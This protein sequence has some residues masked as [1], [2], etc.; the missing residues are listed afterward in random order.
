MC[1]PVL[2]FYNSFCCSSEAGFVSAIGPLDWA[3]Y[4]HV[5]NM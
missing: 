3:S 4:G 1:G 5:T 2:E